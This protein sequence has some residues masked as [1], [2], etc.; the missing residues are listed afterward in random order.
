MIHFIADI[1]KETPL[2]Q[3]RRSSAL[4]WDD[5]VY[6]AAERTPTATSLGS[7]YSAPDALRSLSS[8]IQ[9]GRGEPGTERFQVGKHTVC[10][11]VP[12]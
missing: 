3:V 8:E 9:P 7:V 6:A 2:S 11:L 5:A 1:L 4:A 12:V 10:V